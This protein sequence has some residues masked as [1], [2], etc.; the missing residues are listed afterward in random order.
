MSFFLPW[1]VRLWVLK[2]LQKIWSVMFRWWVAREVLGKKIQ[3]IYSIVSCLSVNYRM[4]DPKIIWA[5]TVKANWQVPGRRGYLWNDVPKPSPSWLSGHHLDHSCN[6]F[7]WRQGILYQIQSWKWPRKAQWIGISTEK[8]SKMFFIC[9]ID[10]SKEEKNVTSKDKWESKRR[11]GWKS[12]DWLTWEITFHWHQ[13][14]KH[15]SSLPWFH[16]MKTLGNSCGAPRYSGEQTALPHFAYHPRFPSTVPVS[17]WDGIGWP[18]TYYVEAHDYN[19]TTSLQGRTACRPQILFGTYHSGSTL[20]WVSLPRGQGT[21][22]LVR[23][24]KHIKVSA[25]KI[26]ST[27]KLASDLPSVPSFQTSYFSGLF[28]Q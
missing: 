5:G 22:C 18:V 26:R 9:N 1:V 27:H 16:N 6:W 23:W 2:T 12:S 11:R 7:S 14:S 3:N 24:T 28:I 19:Q 4:L 20:A 15:L 21:L 17:W 8:S 10:V 25:E 13:L